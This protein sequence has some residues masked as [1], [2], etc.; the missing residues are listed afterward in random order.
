[1]T[2]KNVNITRDHRGYYVASVAMYD[3][4]S[5]YY[6]QPIQADSVTGIKKLINHYKAYSD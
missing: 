5:G 6:F 4:A 2:Y 3:R 1:M